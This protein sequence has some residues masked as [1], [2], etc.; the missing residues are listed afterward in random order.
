MRQIDLNKDWAI[1]IDAVYVD[2]YG[3]E[4]TVSLPVLYHRTCDRPDQSFG[5][6][7]FVAYILRTHNNPYPYTLCC[8]KWLTKKL[9]NKLKFI[10]DGI[11]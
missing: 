6:C 7:T 5:R 4:D 9:F 1:V 3:V 11:R 10:Y 2:S 8:E